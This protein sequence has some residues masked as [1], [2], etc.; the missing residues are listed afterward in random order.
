M[1]DWNEPPTSRTRKVRADKLPRRHCPICGAQ[2]PKA[3]SKYC[4]R[5]CCTIDQTGRESPRKVDDP[6]QHILSRTKVN[7]RGCWEG[8]GFL[9]P[10]GYGQGTLAVLGGRYLAHRALYQL[11]VGPVADNL[12]MDHLCRNPRCCNPKHLE[13]VPQAV[14]M[15]R[16]YVEPRKVDAARSK[17]HCR[18]GH[19]YTTESTGKH[20]N[21]SRRCRT[22]AAEWARRARANTRAAA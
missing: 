2:V 14:N 18:N 9:T 1:T 20:S 8:Q 6:V 10:E 13:P 15:E 11:L 22:C 12:V 16:G 17:T 7:E 3:S 4:S 5:A 21:G 19:P